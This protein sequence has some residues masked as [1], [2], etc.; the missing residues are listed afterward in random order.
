MSPR[1][2]ET[3]SEDSPLVGDGSS[4][5][6]N[7]G[8]KPLSF[9][10]M[11]SSFA[12]YGPSITSRRVFQLL[13]IAIAS[14]ALGGGGL[15]W[16]HHG[17]DNKKV[18]TGQYHLVELQEGE[19]FFDYY[20]FFDGPD[21]IGSAGH[22]TYVPKHRAQDIGIYNVTKESIFMSSKE[23]KQGPR[24]SIRLE[25]KR[26]FNHGLFIIDLDHMPA[27]CGVWPA[28]W[29]TNEDQWPDNGEIDIIE[30]VNY[31]TKA[32]TALHTSDRCDMYAHVPEYNR[33]GTWDWATG[34]FDTYT[35]LPDFNT[36]KPADDCWNLAP[37]QWSNQG[38]VG[39]SDQ[40]GSIGIPFNKQGG[41]VYALEWDP[42][43]HRI[44]SWVF[45]SHDNV[46]PNLVDTLATADKDDRVLPDTDE[47]GLPYAL[48]AIGDGTGC[49][50][51]H[52][53]EMRIVLNL[54]F[55]GTVAGNRFFK[56]CPAE[57]KLFNVDKDPVL[58]CNKYIESNPEALEEAFWKIN[59]V[60]VYQRE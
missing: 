2:K 55:C 48:F 21:S 40:E 1:G 11:S 29:L 33:T 4:S 42:A 8:A 17:N 19:A 10:R 6:N 13:A 18:P 9:R 37:H 59:G 41:G 47:W 5:S 54:A 58:S 44:R 43:N 26:R 57:A 30:G 39:V 50:A 27:G 15:V 32:K 25:G 14:I 56:D 24:E 53:S 7:T 20:D 31:Q 38:C 28:F 12:Y 51:D 52:F 3:T 46:P 35:G 34:L 45:S 36:S 49:S 60:Y 23:T 22:I 16:L